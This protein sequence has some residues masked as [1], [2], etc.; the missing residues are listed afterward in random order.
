MSAPSLIELWEEHT[1][2]EFG[3]RDTEA[4]IATMVED[5]YVNHVPVMTGG[6]GKVALQRASAGV[7]PMFRQ[8]SERMNGIEE[9]G[10]EPGL[11]S[12]ASTIASL[13]SII[14][15]AGG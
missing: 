8:A 12:V 6:Y 14:F 9:I 10:D 11:K 4:T 3:T 13:R 1:K 7:S 5:A 2:H 15:L